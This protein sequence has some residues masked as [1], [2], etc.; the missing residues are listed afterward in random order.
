MQELQVLVGFG[1]FVALLL[2]G[3]HMV[4]TGVQRAFGKTFGLWIGRALGSLPRAFLTGLGITAAI[5]S[6]T[7]TGLM[8]TGFAIDGLVSLAPG[9]A[10]MLG[11][12]VGTTLIVQ[13]LSFN[14]TYLAPALILAGVWMFRH[15]A[16]GRSRDLG[17][18]FIGLGLL[19]LALNEL[20][21]MFEPLKTAPMLGSAL[22]ALGGM[23][24]LALAASTALT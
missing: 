16:P 17:R 9:L 24:L 19:L 11:A 12:N 2:W 5:Q 6:S 20:V 14:P 7:A 8:I 15:Y 21:T 22:Q 1:G 23:P 4:Q 18:V 3:V 13:V 10:A